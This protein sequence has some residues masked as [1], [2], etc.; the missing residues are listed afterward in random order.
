RGRARRQARPPPARGF[1]FRP[2][3]TGPRPRAAL[4]RP[5]PARGSGFSIFPATPAQA[6]RPLTT[7]AAAP[8]P[9]HAAASDLHGDA[10]QVIVD[11]PPLAPNHVRVERRLVTAAPGREKAGTNR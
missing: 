11:D 4:A 10:V 5:E 2:L 1:P 6:R 8:L 3:A 9:V 7:A